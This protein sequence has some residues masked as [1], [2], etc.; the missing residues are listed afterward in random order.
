MDMES[1]QRA[2]PKPSEH[3][4][5]S[6]ESIAQ[7]LFK[8]KQMTSS[9]VGILGNFEDRFAQL[10]EDMKAMNERIDALRV[11]NDNIK[12]TVN[13]VDEVI[14]Q[15][16]IPEE[17]EP[18]IMEGINLDID[19]FLHS[20]DR[21]YEA[22]SFFA[23]HNSYRGSSKANR[24]LSHLIVV[25][26]KKLEAEYTHTFTTAS[27]TVDPNIIKHR[28]LQ[29]D[30]LIDTNQLIKLQKMATRLE[31]SGSSHL[32][33]Y[34]E[35]R[36]KFILESLYRLYPEERKRSLGGKMGKTKAAAVAAGSA[37][38]NVASGG[39]K[40]RRSTDMG[41][42][43]DRS[44][45]N[46]E[47]ET[48]RRF[49]Q[50]GTHPFIF[51]ARFYFQLLRLERQIL[52]QFTTGPEFE[53]Y[54]SETIKASLQLFI[55][56]AEQVGSRRSTSEKI[57]VLL[58][59]LQTMNS[60]QDVWENMLGNQVRS[61][62]TKTLETMYHRASK[63]LK[64]Y[65][66]DILQDQKQVFP[67]G[68]LHEITVMSVS[69]V[70]RLIEYQ[71]TVEYILSHYYFSND[72]TLE[73]SSS[74]VGRYVHILLADLVKNLESKS[75]NYRDRSLA[76]IF[77]LSNVHHILKSITNSNLINIVSQRVRETY[78]VQVEKY[79]KAYIRQSWEKPLD[80]LQDIKKLP[81]VGTSLSRSAKR[82]IKHRLQKFNNA[83]QQL[84][85]THKM[86]SIH[87]EQLRT[88]LVK[89]TINTVKPVYE[90][91]VRYANQVNFTSRKNKYIVYDVK[92]VEDML[93][94]FFQSDSSTSADEP[95]SRL[96]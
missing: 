15:F 93:Y 63:I 49:Y 4:A 1:P 81:P 13:N 14:E 80:Y 39:A 22:A 26:T 43:G 24:D 40:G 10:D 72:S 52:S 48:E 83:F 66:D 86:Y 64:E 41:N 88:E 87:D 38:V 9:M 34:K 6:L 54:F 91:F 89:L 45:A 31:G 51:F 35:I 61:E 59:V 30:D 33:T 65:C 17:E 70:T 3:F 11:S 76:S 95:K 36:S 62:V 78:L 75:K 85:R 7:N 18:R 82:D 57:F 44:T 84:H 2:P 21:I 47:T 50:A 37:A 55:I 42:S 74:Y 96:F 28:S 53:A 92:T 94:Q 77:M 58:D 56:K 73:E 68:L 71:D 23:E 27:K 19:S 79:Q 69:F 32:P 8:A 25:A 46:E 29:I 16:N 90:T 5:Q 12:R 20:F 67:D 60:Q